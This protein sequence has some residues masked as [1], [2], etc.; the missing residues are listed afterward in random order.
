MSNVEPETILRQAGATPLSVDDLCG[1]IVVQR[2]FGGKASELSEAVIVDAVALPGEGDPLLMLIVETITPAGTHDIYQLP[3]GV[4]SAGASASREERPETVIAKRDGVIIYDALCERDQ[5]QRLTKLLSE[6]ASVASGSTTLRFHRAREPVGAAGMELRVLTGE[7]SN[8]S[9]VLGERHILKAFRRIEPG[10]NPE[11]EMLSFLQQHGFEH[12]APV[13]AWY[14]Y[15]GSL[16][17]STLGVMQPFLQNA[18]DGWR[19]VCEALKN[20]TE[21]RLL[22]PLQDLGTVTGKMHA[23]LAS[24]PEDVEF[25]PE[26][27]SDE[28]VALLTATIDEQIERMFISMPER[29]ELQPL[30][31]RGEELR[32]RLALLSHT[33]VGGRLIR[34]HGD[35]HLGQT[36]LGEGGWVVLDFEGEPRRPM[37]ERRRKRSPLRDV[38]GMLRSL[39]YATLASEVLDGHEPAQRGWEVAAR[40]RF[41]AG[42]LSEM[43]PAMLPAGAQAIEKQLAM[44]ELEKMLYELRYE[45]T[46]RPSW[47]AVPVTAIVRTLDS[48]E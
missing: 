25:A 23:A 10:I 32:D 21:E 26:T 6:Q 16:M 22:S 3:V 36:M 43:D 20:G 31:G 48:E 39:S 27:P 37:R 5:V 45:L 34:C 44:F 29:A 9:V 42:Y 13:Q 7:Q 12:I 38:A 1:W 35:Y 40:E 17:E 33:A 11:L 47:L 15:E 8:T 30:L 24:D 18:T 2:W 14:Q 4:S 19:L 41:L 46:N 28:H